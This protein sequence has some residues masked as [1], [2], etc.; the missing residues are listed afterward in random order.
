MFQII[1]DNTQVIRTE[2]RYELPHVYLVTL[3]LVIHLSWLTQ[4]ARQFIQ[5]LSELELGAP[6]V[7]TYR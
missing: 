3:A 4:A 5:L 6:V 1:L 7:R 2:S